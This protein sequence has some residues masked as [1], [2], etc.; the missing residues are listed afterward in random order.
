M[1]GLIITHHRLKSYSKC[2]EK[3]MNFLYVI[4][5]YIYILRFIYNNS[6]FTLTLNKTYHLSRYQ[7]R[8]SYK[9]SCW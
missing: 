7:Q 2:V 3:Y 6:Q 8:S 4:N 9:L 5:S 1:T